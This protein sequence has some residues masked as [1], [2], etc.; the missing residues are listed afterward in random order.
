L[1][2]VLILMALNLQLTLDL[3]EEILM[4]LTVAMQELVERRA[5]EER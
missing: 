3:L 5:K 4:V 2:F 1:I